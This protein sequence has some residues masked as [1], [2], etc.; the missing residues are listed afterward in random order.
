MKEYNI[1]VAEDEK[2]INELIKISLEKFDYNVFQVYDG[3]SAVEV[4]KENDID[5]VI[6]DLMLPKLSGEEAIV[7]I[8]EDSYCPII[9]VSAKSE[10]FNKVLGLNL[11]ADDYLT[12]PFNEIELAARVNSLIRRTHDYSENTDQ[13]DDTITIGGIS[14]SLTQKCV[15]VDG[16]RKNLTAIEFNILKLLMSNPD[17]VFS[18]EEIYEKVWTE[19]A[20]ET[21]T[22]SV[23]IK[24]IRDKIEIDPKNPRYLLVSWGIGYKFVK[25]KVM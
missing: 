22:V 25:D 23:H 2:T 7:K 18:T 19:P 8:R 17:R 11:G 16:V 4:F 24:R 3:K 12:K 9:I 14:L 10:N 20:I 15:F 21:R 5:L 6:M 1:L 13:N